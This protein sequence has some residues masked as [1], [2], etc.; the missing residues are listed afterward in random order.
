MKITS[1]IEYATR[2]MVTLA[3]HHGESAIPADKLSAED[4][5]P[6][7][8]VNQL[9]LRLRRA[10]LVESHRGTGGGY[11]LSRAPKEITL[12]QV[13]RAVDG[14][15]FEDVC[16]KF[17]SADKDCHHQ[18]QCSISPVWKKLGKLVE[19]YV[20][21]VTLAAILETQ[22]GGCMASA[23]SFIKESRA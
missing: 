10:G 17:N 21:G 6:T 14:K 22:G 13:I 1:S 9:L 8:Y 5:V 3:R 7:D 20:D 2:L 18:G 11:A 12:G 23:I 15:V 16:D 19:D 4:G